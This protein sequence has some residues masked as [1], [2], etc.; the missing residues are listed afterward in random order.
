MPSPA[1]AY[2]GDVNGDGYS[3]V[4]FGDPLFDG[5]SQNQGRVL[6][7]AGSSA[8]LEVAPLAEIT[9]PALFDDY[10]IGR[11]VSTAGDVDGDGFDD[12]VYGAKQ[13]AMVSLGSPS[14]PPDTVQWAFAGSQP[15][16]GVKVGSAGDQNADGFQD[17]FVT[18]FFDAGDGQVHMFRGSKE[19]P[20]N[21]TSQTLFVSTR[22]W[23]QTASSAGDFNRDGYTDFVLSYIYLPLYYHGR[24]AFYRGGPLGLSLFWQF[25][26]N[27]S[28]PDL[29]G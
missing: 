25:D 18:E 28:F 17:F 1:G 16:F 21:A 24:F 9:Q 7:Y 3:D 29:G 27:D 15:A 14:G 19:G 10:R 26:N 2:A 13:R 20:P 6:V 12:I 4:V 8:G 23:V 5:L 22:V 11:S